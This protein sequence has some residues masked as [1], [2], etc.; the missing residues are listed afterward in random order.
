M[1][2]HLDHAVAAAAPSNGSFVGA[3]VVR[4]SVE[5]SDLRRLFD[6]LRRE[7]CVHSWRN[8]EARRRRSVQDLLEW[9]NELRPTE[10]FFFYVEH[11]GKLHLVAGSTVATRMS[12]EF[13]HAGFCVLSRCYIMPEFRGRGFYRDILRYRLDHCVRRFGPRLSAVHIG[14]VDP[15]VARVITRVS[16]PGW[17]PF[18]HLGEE[19]LHV[20][21]QTR[22]VDDY[23]MLASSYLRRL[24]AGLAGH[25]AP[26]CVV[27]LRRALGMLRGAEPARD[28]GL[29]VK[30]GFADACAEGWFEAH[31]A[32]AF[33]QLVAFCAA[34]PLIGFEESDGKLRRADA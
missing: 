24:E 10:L 13:P 28:V 5:P 20:S 15:R 14:T 4:P 1:G 26:A 23:I 18:I 7:N 29:R 2:A 11:A 25:A 22:T 17:P 34:V 3:F 6:C 32:A 16:R 31:D 9:E 12:N 33:E 27:E 19:K 8:I 21:A 30:R